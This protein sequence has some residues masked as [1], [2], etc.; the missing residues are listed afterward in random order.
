M[1]NPVLYYAIWAPLLFFGILFYIAT[2][3]VLIRKRTDAILGRSFFQIHI[4]LGVVEIW[5][6]I[7]FFMFCHHKFLVV[8]HAP[9]HG[10]P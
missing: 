4:V 10:P 8:D 1:A 2:I 9:E 3:I 7:S 6:V 5:T